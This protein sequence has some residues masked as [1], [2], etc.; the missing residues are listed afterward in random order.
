MGGRE[1]LYRDELTASGLNW[2]AVEELNQ[3]LD[4]RAKIRHAHQ[5][6]EAKVTPLAEDRVYVKFREPQMAITPGQAV[7]FYQGDTVL[8][9][10]TIERM[11]G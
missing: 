1:E 2:I 9:G 11:K 4:V 3:P 10:G 8:G 7:V 6:A 5:E